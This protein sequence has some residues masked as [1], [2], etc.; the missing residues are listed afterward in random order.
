MESRIEGECDNT[1][2]GETVAIR[3][4]PEISSWM[5]KAVEQSAPMSFRAWICRIEASVPGTGTFDSIRLWM[6]AS[7]SWTAGADKDGN[8]KVPRFRVRPPD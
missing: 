4:D 6:T 3:I 7:S 1:R 5:V 2:Q 8:Q